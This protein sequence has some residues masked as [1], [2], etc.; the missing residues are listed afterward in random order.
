MLTFTN[1]VKK[2]VLDRIKQELKKEKL[3]VE[4]NQTQLQRLIQRKNS[5]KPTTKYAGRY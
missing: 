1:S 4:L 5:P 2:S 3:D